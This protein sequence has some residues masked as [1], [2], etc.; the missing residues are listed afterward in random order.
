MIC[1]PPRNNGK[2]MEGFAELLSVICTDY[3]VLIITWDWILLASHNMS[4]GPTHTQGHTL[5][6]VI[7]KDVDI[8]SIYIKDLA[9]SDHFCVFFLNCRSSQKFLQPLCLLRKGSQMRILAQLV[10]GD[11]ICATNCKCRDN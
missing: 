10:Y 2:F 11:H 6:L 5:D 7:S 4:R 8:L 3:N 1:K 9:I